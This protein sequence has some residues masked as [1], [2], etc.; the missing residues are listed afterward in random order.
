MAQ[1]CAVQIPEEHLVASRGRHGEQAQTV[2]NRHAGRVLVHRQSL[3]LTQWKR[4]ECLVRTLDRHQRGTIQRIAFVLLAG[5]HGAVRGHG[6]MADAVHLLG[7]LFLA[8]QRPVAAQQHQARLHGIEV[9]HLA[10]VG[11][12]ADTAV[13]DNQSF[14]VGHPQQLMRAEAMAGVLAGTHQAPLL[15]AVD[16]DHATAGVA[17][18]VLGGVEPV[19]IPVEHPMAIEMPVL[20]RFDDLQQAA[21]AAVDHVAFAAGAAADEH[22]QRQVWV[23]IG[24]VA[25]LGHRGGERLAAVEVIADRIV[26]SFCIVAGGQQQW[27]LR[28]SGEGP[29][30]Q[31]RG[32]EQCAAQA[33][34]RPAF[35]LSLRRG[36]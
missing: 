1:L 26:P 31:G 13:G 3:R 17:G 35:H 18:V 21:V 20:G 36:R 6:Q 27:L 8:D 14:A 24:I 25:A 15:D 7:Q 12:G 30:T 10:A 33:E 11:L 4:L 2:V 5:D 16:A 23:G 19:A 9:H 22:G 29:A 34:E 32:G 28:L